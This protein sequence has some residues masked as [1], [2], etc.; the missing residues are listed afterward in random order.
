M[1]SVGKARRAEEFA[2]LVDGGGRQ[3]ARDA[4]LLEF[5]NALRET[6]PVEARA[7]FVADLRERLM[8]EADTALVKTDAR[9]T[10]PVRTRTR[11][12]RRIAI[13]AGAAVFVAG[14][15][16]MAVAA[17]NALPGD[18]LYPIKRVLES[19]ET[20]LTVDDQARASQMLDN[21]SDRLAEAEALA[22]RDSAESQAALPQALDDFVTQANDAADMLIEDYE[23]TG[24]TASIDELR[25]FTQQSLD[26]LTELTTVIPD[27]LQ[28]LISWA[29]EQLA[30]IDAR[31]QAICPVCEGGITEIPAQLINASLLPVNPV[32][33]QPKLEPSG[34]AEVT[35]PLKELVDPLLDPV[36]GGDKGDTSTDSGS[37]SGN[38]APVED[39]PVKQITKDVLGDGKTVGP[40]GG[41]LD[42]LLEPLVDPL[43][44]E[45][46]LLDLSGN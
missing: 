1:I 44:G 18:A 19:A 28:G 9:L 16:S 36:T 7:D 11:R 40:L 12:D 27:G 39:D 29:A 35:S 20:S 31:V 8:A 23:K 5:V 26:L 6:V 2:A 38:Q 4:E 30:A 46:G 22:L 34:D 10:L 24:D 37:G 21:A 15:S 42:P 3:A 45:D 25:E 43:L 41:L 14:T 13:A 32:A 17:Q 33:P